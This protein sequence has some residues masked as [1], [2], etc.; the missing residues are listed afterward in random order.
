M[1]IVIPI[2][3]FFVVVF[4]VFAAA[5]RDLDFRTSAKTFP[6]PAPLTQGDF[7]YPIVLAGKVH[8]AYGSWN[9]VTLMRFLFSALVGFTTA[10]LL[11]LLSNDILFLLGLSLTAALLAFFV[12][13]KST[14]GKYLNE[15][16]ATE[17]SGRGVVI[18][19]GRVKLSRMLTEPVES[20]TGDEPNYY[21]IPLGPDTKITR[22]FLISGGG[23]IFTSRA[24]GVIWILKAE[25]RSV[26]LEENRLNAKELSVFLSSLVQQG[27]AYDPDPY[28]IYL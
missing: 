26:T 7:C 28:R 20:I 12:A 15:S 22:S 4:F 17:T 1:F 21:V 2:S 6:L 10:V 16:V 25:G 19:R 27:C 24:R 18:E 11:L 14:E 13:T 5:I 23:D 8:D 3:I 9:R